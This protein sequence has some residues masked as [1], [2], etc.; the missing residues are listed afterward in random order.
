MI[1]I[2][3][4]D[5]VW[6]FQ[7]QKHKNNWNDCKRNSILLINFGIN[8]MA[9]S[10]ICFVLWCRSHKKSY[11]T[12]SVVS[13]LVRLVASLDLCSLSIIY[14]TC[15]PQEKYNFVNDRF[16]SQNMVNRGVCAQRCTQ[17]YD[18]W[19]LALVRL[20]LFEFVRSWVIL[21]YLN[22]AFSCVQNIKFLNAI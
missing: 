19:M 8:I 21:V 15:N 9:T 22:R 13:K 11:S 17:C 6:C 2:L 18:G 5:I 1:L 14:L 20:M 4:F 12:S 3:F 10:W 16:P 7:Y